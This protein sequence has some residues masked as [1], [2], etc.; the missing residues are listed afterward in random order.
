[1]PPAALDPLD[2]VPPLAGMLR[3]PEYWAA[4]RRLRS[5]A[6]LVDFYARPLAKVT[7]HEGRHGSRLVRPPHMRLV[8]ESDDKRSHLRSAALLPCGV[9]PEFDEKAAADLLAAVSHCVSCAA[10]SSGSLSAWRD[11]QS[12]ALCEVEC[13]LR[14][15]GELVSAQ[16]SGSAYLLASHMNLPFMAA[17]VAAVGWPDV[18]CVR[19]WFLGHAVV[20]DIPDT[21]L[22][23]PKFTDFAASPAEV[24][25]VASN[26]LWNSKLARSLS[27]G[28]ARALVDPEL[29]ARLEGVETA[30]EKELGAEVVRGP[31]SSSA[32]DARF[33][34]GAWRAQR[35][36]GVHQ[37]FESDGSPKIRAIDNSAANSCN[38]A[39]RT[40]ETI[41]P[42]SFA[43]VALCARLFL[44]CC[45]R[46]G[47]AA[48]AL[49]LGLDDMARAYRRVPVATPWLTVFAIWSVR[50]RRVEYYYLDG[51]CFGFTSAVLNFNAFPH[52]VCALSRVFFAVPCDHFYDDYMI[53]DPALAGVSGQSCLSLVH[54]LLGQS[55]EPKKRKP[56]GPRNI[57]LG[58]QLD[59]SSA[60]TALVV[61]ASAT[62]ERVS[63]LLLDLAT[64]RDADFLSPAHASSLR[65][66]LG[67]VFGTS[68]FRF[69]YA[70]LQ[71][72]MQREYYDVSTA[73]SPALCEMHDFLECVLPSLPPM[74]L[75]L[76][77]DRT[78][79]LI[80]YTDAMF[81]PCGP[82]GGPF[83]R[84]GWCVFDP[85]TRS[86]FHS[87]YEL[88]EWYFSFF[89][90]G[91]KTYIMQ[92]EGIGALAPLLSL[93]AL[94]RGR[95]VV[96]FQDNTGALSALVH[97]YASKPDMT[98]L[99]NAYHLAQFL[100]RARVWFEWIPSEANLADLP[101]RLEYDEFF[102]ILP[103]SVWVPTVLPSLQSWLAPLL[104]MFAD[105][106]RHLAAPL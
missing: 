35:R 18:C 16:M 46:L 34:R 30:T 33:G 81:V 15:Y 102:R 74:A 79:P 80:L 56:M 27:A 49:C 105:M 68:Y 65:G 60:H 20:G 19:R 37:G 1:M 87:H 6:L 14:P 50:R 2:F 58:V 101:S 72:L 5:L 38:A 42:P 93:P 22:F 3:P 70:T 104:S 12:A 86:A 28:G 47:L 32:L 84:I 99:V 100:L 23:R 88:P 40:H 24:F 67:F 9:Q 103:G 11:D 26:R 4:I 25:T 57:G 51:H 41:A 21:G 73:F 10:E 63:K 39:T 94:F 17:C 48:L 45:R 76:E 31:F 83:A 97:G 96:Q 91:L 7:H 54:S 13:S 36:F 29:R 69:C 92:S 52:F 66:K 53:V 89:T 75:R 90:P 98:R 44:A 71:P 59:L 62:A 77:P 8:S 82:S 95:S 55:V 43:F 64:C 85:I 61:H 106:G 78:P